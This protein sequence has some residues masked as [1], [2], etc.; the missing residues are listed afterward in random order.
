M[1]LALQIYQGGALVPFFAMGPAPFDKPQTVSHAIS[2]VDIAPTM[3]DLAGYEYPY[4]TDGQSFLPLVRGDEVSQD[5]S[6]LLP[7]SLR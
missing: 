4:L 7:H 2:T 3:M 6:H 5:E 1:C